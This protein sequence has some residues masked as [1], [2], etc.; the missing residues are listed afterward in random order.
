MKRYTE[1]RTQGAI[2]VF[3]SLFA[4]GAGCQPRSDNAA[5]TDRKEALEKSDAEAGI[6]TDA[7]AAEKDAAAA[8]DNDRNERKNS[9]EKDGKSL[10][11][12]F[13]VN[14]DEPCDHCEKRF[15]TRLNGK[16]V[17]DACYNGKSG[18]ICKQLAACAKQ[19]KCGARQVADCYCGAGTTISECMS[20]GGRGPCKAAVEAAAET[21]DPSI[22]A[23]RYADPAY[24]VGRAMA[25]VDCRRSYCPKCNE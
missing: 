7:P 22:I 6:A 8:R 24:P 4:M 9:A 21:K 12:A 2:I 3:A 23:T 25:L 5:N 17:V 18:D 13:E 16:N 10:F 14:P 20:N 15:C 19:T 1:P 11:H